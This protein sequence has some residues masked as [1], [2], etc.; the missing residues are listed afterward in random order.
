MS[1][2]RPAIFA[3]VAMLALGSL[4]FSRLHAVVGTNRSAATGNA[5]HLQ[6]VER[7]L[8]RNV[9]LTA[10][11]WLVEHPAL[12]PPV[13]NCYRLYYAVLLGVLIWVYV[14]HPEVYRQVRRSLLGLVLWN[15]ICQALRAITGQLV[16]RRPTRRRLRGVAELSSNRAN[17]RRP[18][19]IA[20]GECV[21]MLQSFSPEA[22]ALLGRDVVAPHSRRL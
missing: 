18:A 17:C 12:I 22:L 5:R 20:A 10:N 21:L 8:H 6:S 11:R 13:V 9:E 16:A 1:R 3:E 19:R 4:L 2:R 7:S 15:L 14:C